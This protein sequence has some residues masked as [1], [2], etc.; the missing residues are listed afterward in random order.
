MDEANARLCGVLE[1]AEDGSYRIRTILPAP[2]ATGGP[3]PHVHF[4]ATLPDGSERSFT[5]QWTEERRGI[6]PASGERSSSVRP[7][8][9]GDDGVLRLVYDLVI[10]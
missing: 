1:S 7:L 8:V 3:R 4:V 2:Y 9:R 10:D 6:D 5:L